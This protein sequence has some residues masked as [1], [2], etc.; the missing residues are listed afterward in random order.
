M[1]DETGEKRVRAGD[2]WNSGAIQQA[3]HPHQSSE[4]LAV[5]RRLG[6]RRR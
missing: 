6:I 4:G 3:D 5:S 1:E 2:Q